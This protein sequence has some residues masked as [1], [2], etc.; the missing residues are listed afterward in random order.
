M[1]RK[2]AKYVLLNFF[3]Y[4]LIYYQNYKGKSLKASDF[5]KFKA[6]KV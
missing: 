2:V 3:F 5:K 6:Q 1:E 4:K